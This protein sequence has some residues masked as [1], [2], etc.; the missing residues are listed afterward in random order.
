MMRNLPHAAATLALGIV[1]S[2]PTVLYATCVTDAECDNGD[3]CSV[4]D[5]CV[6][7][8][9]Q[10]GGGGDANDDLVCDAELDPNTSINLTKLT[11]KR[12][13]LVR[14]DSSAAKG[15]GDL[16][17]SGSPGSAFTGTAG[18]SFRVKDTLSE[19]PP[20]GDGMDATVAFAPGDCVVKSVGTTSCRS[21]NHLSFAK[22]K[23]NKTIA[24]QYR[25]SFRLKG[26]GNLTGPFFGPAR[27][28]LSYNGNKRAADT[29]SDCKLSNS[30]LR[31]REF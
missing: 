24:G 12:N 31:C 26:L 30:G 21:A 23:P 19:A 22:F 20:P 16:F 7:G 29:I 27:M 9:C 15:A 28:V 1:L 18:V 14:S 13:N 4:P 25:F 3:V 8:T 2:V 11:M 6:L 17:T 10:L 5:T